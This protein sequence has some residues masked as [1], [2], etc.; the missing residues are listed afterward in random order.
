[1]KG[2]LDMENSIKQLDMARTFLLMG[3]EKITEENADIIPEGFPNSLRWQLGHILVSCEYLVFHQAG[4]EMKIPEGY[5]EMFARGT[6]PKDWTGQPPSVEEL[7][8]HLSEQVGRLKETFENRLDEKVQES[9]QAGPY[10]LKTVEEMIM[11]ALFHESE[12][13]G[14][15]K[16]LKSGIKGA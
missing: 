7:K 10:E 8:K 16:G 9:F 4:E 5:N 6:S 15:I 12:H 1:M 11:F 3:A 2:V 14:C 13:I